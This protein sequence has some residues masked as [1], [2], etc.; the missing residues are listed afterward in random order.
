[1]LTNEEITELRALIAAAQLDIPGWTHGMYLKMADRATQLVYSTVGHV[2]RI[3][4]LKITGEHLDVTSHL[5]GG[6]GESLSVLK[7]AGRVVFLVHFD[8]ADGTLDTTTGIA[9]AAL[10]QTVE[11]FQLT[12]SDGTGFGF[13][14]LVSVEFD[15]PVRGKVVGNVILDITGP[16]VAI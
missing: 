7:A 6:W 3:K 8:K 15:Q 5:S 4:G 16:V 10:A 13:S 14:A 9:A 12:F 1:M 11:K 2:L